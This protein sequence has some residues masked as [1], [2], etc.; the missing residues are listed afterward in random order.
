[1]DRTTSNKHLAS[2]LKKITGVYNPKERESEEG[3]GFSALKEGG[4]E[5]VT[6]NP[7]DPVVPVV[8]VEDVDEPVIKK[9][10]KRDRDPVAKTVEPINIFVPEAGWSGKVEHRV[11]N[12]FIRGLVKMVS[13]I[14]TDKDWKDMGDSGM[15]YVVKNAISLWGQVILILELALLIMSCT[16]KIFDISFFACIFCP[17]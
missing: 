9:R 15:H 14:S 7:V 11:G 4:T 16:Y 8:D 5:S 17:G 6:P 12:Y 2:S 13:R 10:R 3:T 1:M